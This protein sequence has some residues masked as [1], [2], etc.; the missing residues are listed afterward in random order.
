MSK[1]NQNVKQEFIPQITVTIEEYFPKKMQIFHCSCGED[2]LIVPDA[3]AMNT[4]LKNHLTRHREES[5][6]EQ[7]LVQEMLTQ[8]ANSTS[9]KTR[10]E[11][12]LNLFPYEGFYHFLITGFSSLTHGKSFFARLCL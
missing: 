8:I 11:V 6:T 9:S 4:A 7:T 5:L 2:I 10:S 3:K 1:K 12:A